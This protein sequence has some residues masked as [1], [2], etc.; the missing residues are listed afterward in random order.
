MSDVINTEVLDNV[1]EITPEID[2]AP[3][4]SIVQ[5]EGFKLPTMDQFQATLGQTATQML[6]S[7]MLVAAVRGSIWAGKK[8]YE[9]SRTLIKKGGEKLKELRESRKE[10]KL[11]R[12][13]QASADEQIEQIAQDQEV[14]D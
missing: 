5:K 14:E 12:D 11:L 6:A 1:E 8:V 4:S 13:V 10:E 9:G 7:A 3:E 2:I